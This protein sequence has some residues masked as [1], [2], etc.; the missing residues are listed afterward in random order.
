[1]KCEHSKRRY[2]VFKIRSKFCLVKCLDFNLILLSEEITSFNLNKNRHY[3][4]KWPLLTTYFLLYMPRGS[5]THVVSG[6]R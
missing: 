2:L 1:M 4:K 6:L 3:G 5:G